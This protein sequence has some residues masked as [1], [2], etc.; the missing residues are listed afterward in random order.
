VVGDNPNFEARA[1]DREVLAWLVERM[2]PDQRAI[3]ERRV[4]GEDWA[5][6][7]LANGTTA[8]AV[9]KRYRRGLDAIVKRLDEQGA[10]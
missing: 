4:A 6:I 1:A 3:A 8:E 9:R 2:T 10:S 5:E 7:A